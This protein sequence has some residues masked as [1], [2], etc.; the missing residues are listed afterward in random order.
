VQEVIA[1]LDIPTT[2]PTSVWVSRERSDAHEHVS[3]LI[4]SLG[5]TLD[6]NDL[7]LAESLCI[8]MPLGGDATDSC[9]SQGLD[10]V[11]T[12]ALDTV[13]GLTTRR[14]LMTTPVTSSAMKAAAHGLFT[15]DGVP[16][17]IIHDSAGFVAQR[18]LAEIVNIGCDIVQQRITTPDDLDKAVTLGLGYP[19]GPLAWGD[20]LGPRNVLAML[21]EMTKLY[22]DPRY[23]A[24]PWLTRRAKLG[25]SLLT[26][27][28]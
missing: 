17:S 21:A 7:P 3:D 5:G 12:V 6:T 11:R 14:T 15:N 1:E 22:G 28:N 8:V 10:P 2:R 20:E 19:K 25:L 16:V 9:V 26:P 27:E 23:R 4:V 13:C 24:S 18:V